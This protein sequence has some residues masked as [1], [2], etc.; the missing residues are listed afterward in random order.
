MGQRRDKG[1]KKNGGA[2]NLGKVT[3]KGRSRK[4]F[5]GWRPVSEMGGLERK[6]SNALGQPFV[7]RY[8]KALR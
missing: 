7:E 1:K 3:Y 5:W 6:G 8:W 4:S 2:E